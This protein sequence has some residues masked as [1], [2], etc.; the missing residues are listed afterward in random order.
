MAP[1][2]PQIVID[3]LIFGA[4]RERAGADSVPVAV[5]PDAT[6]ADLLVAAGDQYPDLKPYLASVRVAV[7]QHYAP[8]TR[9]LAGATEVALIPP[10]AGGAPRLTV[11]LTTQ[12]IDVDAVHAAIADPAAGGHTVFVGRVR[13]HHD[14]RD[15]A[16]LTYEAYKP[17]AQ[18]QLQD[19]LAA[20]AAAHG[21]TAVAVVHRLGRLD[22]GDA[23][24]ALAASAAHRQETFTAVAAMMDAIKHD[25]PIFKRETYRDGSSDW[26]RCTH[27]HT[28]VL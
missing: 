12:P 22:I 14:G 17:M 25:V 13:N 8:A 3:V 23:A 19:I 27:Q 9:E 24:I 18:Q 11:Q 7:D 20:A 1:V 5:A 6:S 16:H 21:L 4:L 10:V 15:V 28:E 2:Q 26:V